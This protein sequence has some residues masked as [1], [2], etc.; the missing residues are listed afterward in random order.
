MEVAGRILGTI[1]RCWEPDRRS[2]YASSDH[3]RLRRRY[4]G[5]MLLRQR[6]TSTASRNCILLGTRK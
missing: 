1:R 5:A 6:K 4:G 2:D 3:W